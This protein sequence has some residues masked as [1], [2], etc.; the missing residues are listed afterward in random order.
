MNRSKRQL[1]S[2]LLTLVMIVTMIPMFGVTVSAV[3]PLPNFKVTEDG[4]ISWDHVKGA[5]EYGLTGLIKNTSLRIWE[6]TVF[7]GE[8]NKAEYKKWTDTGVTLRLQDYLDKEAVCLPGKY[9]L[10]ITAYR[11]DEPMDYESSFSF[12]FDSA[13]TQL[14]APQSLQWHGTTVTWD[15]VPN[16]TGYQ[17]YL[18]EN[19]YTTIVADTV[20]GT[21]YTF[22][23]SCFMDSE[24]Y[25]YQF[26]VRAQA[27]GYVNSNN[28]N[29]DIV[30]GASILGGYDSSAG[31]S[32]RVSG[33][34][35][36]KTTAKS[37]EKVT[38]TAIP[39]N[40]DFTFKSWN[41]VNG[42]LEFDNKNSAAAT[43]TM[44][45]GNISI[46]GNYKVNASS[47]GNSWSGKTNPFVDVSKGTY[48]YDPVLWA[49]YS[50]PQVTNGMDADHFGP[51]STVTRGQCVTFLWRA[52]GCPE[53]GITTN[54]FV[55]IKTDEYWYKPILWAVEKGITK[56]TDE[57][58]FT[59]NQKL[60]TA[61]IATFLY[62]TLGIGSDG[63]YEEAGNW[64][65]NDGLLDETGLSVSDNVD[66]P[67]GAVVTFLYRELANAV[68]GVN[69]LNKDDFLIYVEDS[70]NITG[71]GR[72]ITGKVL[73]G[74]IRTGDKVTLISNDETTGA[75]VRAT[76]T[77][78]GIEMF[79]KLLD[80][81]EK[82]DNV[83][84][85]LSADTSVKTPRGSAL[86]NEESNLKSTPGKFVGTLKRN[87]DY[88]KTILTLGDT[89]QVYWTG[90]DVT[91]MLVD[92]N[93]SD[94]QPNTTREGV[95]LTLLYPAVL[96]I[97]QELTIREGGRTYGTFT[98]TA[99]E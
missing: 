19:E 2:L 42:S 47:S 9:D 43:F 89:F 12:T 57:N 69:E 53:P 33:G 64:A 81:A 51:A 76:Y 35:A 92:L 55:D 94:L 18:D 70:Y 15:P 63:W 17:V 72:V 40:D 83:G 44:P 88:A 25:V 1:T 39:D 80:E 28:G 79:H 37:G 23:S 8:M 78:E 10:T 87:G 21:S 22:D 86:V 45:T 30:S 93:G 13:I 67:R 16:A 71:R 61:H 20:S 34:S 66:C 62:R 96:Y 29:S 48:Y 65:K 73:N 77:V 75:P 52:M 11:N 84:I 91:A 36:D 85:L 38:L 4:V 6:P 97:G 46:S 41:A 74:S 24:A 50:D 95:S 3:S 68:S 58:H 14:Q 54:P 99:I 31:G 98:I 59:S 60:S 49:Y 27:D 82:G 26:V 7:A 56:G 90:Y 5:D 32:V